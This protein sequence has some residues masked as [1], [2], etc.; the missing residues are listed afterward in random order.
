MARRSSIILFLKGD[1]IMKKMLSV[2]VALSIILVS[3][4]ALGEGTLRVGMECGY[5]PYNWHQVDE[6]EYTA[7]ISDGSGY[8]DGYDVQIAKRIAEALDMDLVVVKTEWEGL[9]PSLTSGNIDMII[10]GMSPTEQRKATIDFSDY[11]YQSELVVVVRKDGAYAGAKELADLSGATIVAQLNTFHDTVIDQIPGVTHGMAMETFPAMIV[12]L[13][14]G[15]IDGYIA[16]RPG[17]EADTMANTDLTYIKFEEGKG[18]EASADD[19][20]IAIG[21]VYGS[22]Y[23]EKINETLAGISEDERVQIMLDATARQPLSAE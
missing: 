7:P 2:L 20:A 23:K 11:Y 22:P 17:A 12:A 16:E 6:N 8:A 18:F 14:S 19:T 3:A 10:A 21:L 5:A 1:C 9:V 4:A 15:A 13:S